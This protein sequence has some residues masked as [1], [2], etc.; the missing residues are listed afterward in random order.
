MSSLSPIKSREII[1][2]LK[3]LDFDERRQKGSHLFLSHQD[4]RTTVVPI[5][6][7]KQIGIGLLRSILHDIKLSPEEFEKLK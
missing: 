7:S 2:I 3:K 5:H 4:G 6:Q 1:K